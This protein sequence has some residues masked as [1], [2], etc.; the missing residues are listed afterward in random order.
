LSSEFEQPDYQ[1]LYENHIRSLM[2]K[3]AA[4]L[5]FP[6]SQRRKRQKRTRRL[7]QNRVVCFSDFEYNSKVLEEGFEYKDIVIL[8]RKRS[9]GIAIANYLTEQ[10]IP[11]CSE[12][13]M[14]QNA[15]EVRLIIH[16]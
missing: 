15:T 8:T 14:I 16:L 3:L 5:I 10:N 11:F 9:Q 7:R 12:T 13:L 6:L 1:D 2:I 4:T